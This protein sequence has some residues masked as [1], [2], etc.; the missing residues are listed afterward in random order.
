M[1]VVG[2]EVTCHKCGAKLNIQ[3]NGKIPV[4]NAKGTN[5]TCLGSLEQPR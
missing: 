1:T 3:G 2:P 5:I 4:H